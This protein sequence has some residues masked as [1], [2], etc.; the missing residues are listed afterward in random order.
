MIPVLIVTEKYEK[1]KYFAHKHGMQRWTF[2][3]NASQIYGIR[4]VE[5][6]YL[7]PYTITAEMQIAI[8]HVRIMGGF[9]KEQIIHD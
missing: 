6:Y 8:D 1:A 3:T 2:V 4:G 5:T 7:E 9:L